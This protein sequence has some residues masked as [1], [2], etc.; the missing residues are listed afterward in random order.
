MVTICGGTKLTASSKKNVRR[1]IF[2]AIRSSL[3]GKAGSIVVCLGTETSIAD[4][5]KKMDS[6][7]GEVDTEADLLAAFYSAHQGP[8]ESVSDWGCRME[9]F[10]EFDAAKRQATVPGSP[11]EVLCS[12]F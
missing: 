12:V 11:D 9:T 10:F 4:I 5:L 8:R 1:R 2:D 7:F 3:H 6:V